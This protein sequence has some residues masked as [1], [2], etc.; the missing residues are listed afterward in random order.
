M[1]CLTRLVEES[2]CLEKLDIRSGVTGVPMSFTRNEAISR[3]LVG[4]R[5]A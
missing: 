4:Y 5:V 2:I 1:R 3:T